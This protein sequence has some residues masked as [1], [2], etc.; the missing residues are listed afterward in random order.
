MPMNIYCSFYIQYNKY[1][2]VL[3]ILKPLIMLYWYWNKK[4]QNKKLAIR[5]SIP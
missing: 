1:V 5:F 4:I 3:F 2:Y